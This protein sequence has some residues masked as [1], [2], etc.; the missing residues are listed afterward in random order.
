MNFLNDISPVSCYF[1]LLRSKFN[2]TFDKA[3]CKGKGNSE[4]LHVDVRIILKMIS[5]LDNHDWSGLDSSE[6]GQELVTDS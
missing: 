1:L 2:C 4:D 5:L 6:S 3:K